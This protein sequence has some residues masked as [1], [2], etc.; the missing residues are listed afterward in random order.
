MTVSERLSNIFFIFSCTCNSWISVNIHSNTLKLT[1]IPYFSRILETRA[2]FRSS[3]ISYDT[4]QNVFFALAIWC[5]V[6]GGKYNENAGYVVL[7][8]KNFEVKMG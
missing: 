6:F 2:L 8:K 1:L 7:E 3:L 5:C 4:T